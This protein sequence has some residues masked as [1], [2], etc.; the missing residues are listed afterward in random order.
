MGAWG[1]MLFERACGIDERELCPFREAKSESAEHTFDEDIC[2]REIL[3]RRLMAQAERIG[4]RIRKK[5]VRPAASPS[6]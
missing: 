3:Q 2:D 4:A 1:R 5:G 6:R